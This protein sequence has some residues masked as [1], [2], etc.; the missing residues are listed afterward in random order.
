MTCVTS[1]ATNTVEVGDQ[2]I[3]RAELDRLGL[4]PKSI[5]IT[6][7]VTGEDGYRIGLEVFH[8]LHCLNL[9]RQSSYPEYY[10]RTEVG[11]DVPVAHKD[12]RGHLGML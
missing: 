8:Q 1:T 11:G 9:L 6:N 2:M 4:D 7:A 3:S 5:K 10:N 12:L